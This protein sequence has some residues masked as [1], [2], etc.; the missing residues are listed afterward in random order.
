MSSAGFFSASLSNDAISAV[1]SQHD[2]DFLDE[3]RPLIY[4]SKAR[5]HNDSR[6]RICT[7]YQP[8]VEDDAWSLRPSLL[9]VDINLLAANITFI[10]EV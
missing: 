2:Q 7:V 1:Y 10:K 3:S 5:I 9:W 8:G 6:I 4:Y